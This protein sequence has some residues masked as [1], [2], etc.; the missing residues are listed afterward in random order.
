MPR[1]NRE[2]GC[3]CTPIAMKSESLS[4]TAVAVD[5]TA[6]RL[7]TGDGQA[8]FGPSRFFKYAV[9]LALHPAPQLPQ[10]TPGPENPSTSKTVFQPSTTEIRFGCDEEGSNE[11][12]KLR[13]ELTHGTRYSALS[14]DAAATTHLMSLCAWNGFSSSDIQ[15]ISIFLELFDYS[16]ASL[17]RHRIISGG[18][19]L[20][21]PL[22]FLVNACLNDDNSADI[23]VAWA[24]CG[25]QLASSGVAGIFTLDS[26]GAVLNPGLDRQTPR[27]VD[28]HL[29]DTSP[30]A[31]S[32]PSER[33]RIRISSTQ[34]DGA[35][36]VKAYEQQAEEAVSPCL[37]VD[38]SQYCDESSENYL[39]EGA[40]SPSLRTRCS[41][42]V[43]D[44]RITYAE[45][46]SA[47]QSLIIDFGQNENGG[48]LVGAYELRSISDQ[49]QQLVDNQFWYAG[50]AAGDYD[51]LEISATISF[52]SQL[53]NSGQLCNGY[54]PFFIHARVTA[55][56]GG[57]RATAIGVFEGLPLAK[58]EPVEGTF[59]PLTLPP[60]DLSIA[61]AELF[62][63][64]QRRNS[65]LDFSYF[66]FGHV[67]TVQLIP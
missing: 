34:N 40:P 47:F 57:Q 45:C 25:T 53:F 5:S 60:R 6:V 31:S 36:V 39:G 8:I 43:R 20:Y 62:S 46:G 14:T 32:I 21:R 54:I 64:Y 18:L 12:A 59:Q 56:V 50:D 4:G 7:E 13:I 23:D 35:C 22:D 48:F 9:H 55:N 63:D 38:V 26:L 58:G 2:C 51:R 11:I 24:N 10:P 61:P 3:C 65:F 49:G 29:F 17:A 44:S 52:N 16:G 19:L 42:W 37:P 15:E 27:G 1:R 33:N 30:G 41:H 28:R 67:P 66:F